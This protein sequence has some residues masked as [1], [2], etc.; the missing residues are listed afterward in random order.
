M[1]Y[2]LNKL[3]PAE[4]NLNKMLNQQIISDLPLK[5]CNLYFKNN[6]NK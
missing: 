2:K 5:Y 4:K 3:N 6:K 1:F